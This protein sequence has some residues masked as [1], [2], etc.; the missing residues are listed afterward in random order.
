MFA[1]RKLSFVLL[2]LLI[3]VHQSIADGV[4]KEQ[5]L[6]I[7]GGFEVETT[8]MSRF[9]L[10]MQGTQNRTS[11]FQTARLDLDIE[12]KLSHF[13]WV[14]DG[15]LQVLRFQGATETAGTSLSPGFFVQ[16][17]DA[18]S[19]HLRF[20]LRDAYVEK[21]T[22]LGLFRVGAQTMHWGLGMLVNNQERPGDFGDHNQVSSA[23]RALWATR[24]LTMVQPLSLMVA[25]DQIIRDDNAEWDRGDDAIGASIALRYVGTKLRTGV[26][27]SVRHQKDR[28]EIDDPIGQRTI[29]KSLIADYFWQLGAQEGDD[30]FRWSGEIAGIWGATDRLFSEENFNRRSRVASFGAVTRLVHTT[31]GLDTGLEAAYASGDRDI[32][33]G[34]IRRFRFATNYGSGLI[35]VDH[36]LP[37]LSARAVDRIDDPELID[38]PPPRLRFA[39]H[40]GGLE[41]TAYLKPSLSYRFSSAFRIDLAYFEYIA[42]APLVDL[43]QTGLNGGY[44]TGFNGQVNPNPRMGREIDAQLNIAVPHYLTSK[45]IDAQAVLVFGAFESA[46]QLSS[47]LQ[48][49]VYL[50]QINLK[51]NW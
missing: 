24:P 2:Y 19:K 18:E 36:I 44:S 30:G 48:E 37:L 16:P 28:A 8:L 14:L 17:R 42:T 50:G 34:T 11:G 38:V 43:Y 40:Q 46:G 32:F 12:G 26:L 9:A 49:R 20:M 25:F 1:K 39:L 22:S 31:D 3:S 47:V 29:V 4:N 10:D 51:A 27:T 45:L 15:E 5:P 33:D 23:I 7:N 41:S 35:L 6:K 21:R 13:K